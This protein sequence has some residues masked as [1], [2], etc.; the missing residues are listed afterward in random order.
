M[1]VELRATGASGLPP[2]PAWEGDP[3]KPA[4]FYDQVGTDGR[5]GGC[6]SGRGVGPR[7]HA[8]SALATSHHYTTPAFTAEAAA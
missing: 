6:P 4:P 3:P 8:R 1:S 5:T 7:P 2:A